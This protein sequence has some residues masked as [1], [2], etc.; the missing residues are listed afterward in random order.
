MAF[1][2]PVHW[3]IT[4]ESCRAACS[5]PNLRDDLPFLPTGF[6]VQVGYC[7]T[8]VWYWCSTLISDETST[9]MSMI[10]IRRV[11]QNSAQ[12][13]AHKPKLSTRHKTLSGSI[14]GRR[15]AYQ[16]CQEMV[17]GS[18]RGCMRVHS[19]GKKKGPLRQLICSGPSTPRKLVKRLQPCKHLRDPN[20][21]FSRLE[22]MVGQVWM[23]WIAPGKHDSSCYVRRVS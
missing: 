20:E 4:L 5:R 23:A 11:G 22:V 1:L 19:R 8:K 2:S 15:A 10:E 9:R 6:W 17:F 18:T 7:V 13:S 3:L 21:I 14:P 12:R 16:G